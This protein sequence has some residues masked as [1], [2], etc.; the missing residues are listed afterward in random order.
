MTYSEAVSLALVKYNW[1]E[2]KSS[3]E[4]YEIAAFIAQ[5]KNL[6]VC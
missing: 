2:E 5:K 1:M 6:H 4:E 3:P